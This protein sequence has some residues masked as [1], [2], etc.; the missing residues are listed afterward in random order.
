MLNVRARGEKE[1]LGP[2]LDC[3]LARPYNGIKQ[4]HHNKS[5]QK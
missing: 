1:L 2:R 4:D 3:E 5:F